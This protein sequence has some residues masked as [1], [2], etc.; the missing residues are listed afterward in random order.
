[1]GGL[2]MGELIFSV[3]Y[4]G[5]LIVMGFIT[6]L[7]INKMDAGSQKIEEIGSVSN[8]KNYKKAV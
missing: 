6:R 8:N 7:F 4:G 5:S 2:F 3:V 1:M